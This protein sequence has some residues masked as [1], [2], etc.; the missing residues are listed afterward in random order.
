MS[1]HPQVRPGVEPPKLVPTSLLVTGGMGVLGCALGPLAVDAGH[2]P[3]MPGVGH[4]N[5]KER[6]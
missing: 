2:E 5:G 1:I 3:T 4:V 6:R